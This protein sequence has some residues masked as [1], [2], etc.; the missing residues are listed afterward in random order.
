M[1]SYSLKILKFFFHRQKFTDTIIQILNDKKE[2][3]VFILWGAF[4]QKKG[5]TVNPQKH[6]ILTA[7]HPSPYSV[8]SFFGCK[9]FSKTNEYL[10]KNGKDP[11]NWNIE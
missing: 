6:C 7:G 9:A 5:K 1:V 10:K 11:I 4:A 2:H 8:N 3:L